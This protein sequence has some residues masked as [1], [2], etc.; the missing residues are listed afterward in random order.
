MIHTLTGL[1]M[2]VT[3]SL[4]TTP[5]VNTTCDS[6][7]QVPQVLSPNSDGINDC[8]QVVFTAR[9]PV[10]FSLK[11]FN[12]WGELMTETNDWTFCWDTS[13]TRKKQR[14][15]VPAGVYFWV[16]DYTYT[17]PEKHSCTGN[18]TIVK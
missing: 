15:L 9:K 14:E 4:T 11:I 18:L 16:M 12:R 13:I 10:E 6:T 17:G 8:F 1:L 2:L 7:V 3:S 5:A